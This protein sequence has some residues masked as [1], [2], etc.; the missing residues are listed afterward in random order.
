MDYPEKELFRRARSAPPADNVPY[1]FEKRI[2]AR[3]REP[4]ASATQVEPG[5]WWT[6][7]FCRAAVPCILLTCVLILWS[8]APANDAKSSY[9]SNSENIDVALDDALALPWDETE[10]LL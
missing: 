2:M 9:A 5:H 7:A 6:I 4:M 8:F 3:I 10:E 1:Q